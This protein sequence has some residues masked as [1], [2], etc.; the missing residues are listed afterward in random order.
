MIGTYE[1][2]TPARPSELD[3]SRHQ[4]RSR[5]P[6]IVFDRA[7]AGSDSATEGASRSTASVHRALAALIGCESLPYV[8]FGLDR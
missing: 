6:G 7:D 2:A 4:I 8:P 5:R 3:G 1:P